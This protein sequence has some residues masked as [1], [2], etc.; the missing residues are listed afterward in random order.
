MTEPHNFRTQ[1]ISLLYISGDCMLSKLVP[2]SGHVQIEHGQMAYRQN[3]T[4]KRVVTTCYRFQHS[5][6]KK[7][8]LIKFPV[9]YNGNYSICLVNKTIIKLLPK[10]C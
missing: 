7:N 1:L 9:N 4:D 10:W 2:G 8:K 3:A 5:N 6:I